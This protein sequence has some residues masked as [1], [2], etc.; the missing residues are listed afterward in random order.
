[1]GLNMRIEK[2][3]GFL[4]V[5]PRGELGA[6]QAAELLEEIRQTSDGLELDF[7]AVDSLDLAVLQLLLVTIASAASR[8][9]PVVVK[10]SDSQV[11]RSTLNL[12]GVRP[13]KCGLSADLVL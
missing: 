1:M 5:R 6:S 12:A 8:R 2:Q 3:E 10:D 11:L 7:S 4:I 13:E 9:G